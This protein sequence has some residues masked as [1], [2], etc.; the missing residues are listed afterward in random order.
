VK[1]M[2]DTNACIRL[3]KGDSPLFFKRI[4]Y[5]SIS[6]VVIPTI[7]RFE[8][9]YGVYKSIR[10]KEN[11]QNLSEFLNDFQVIP[12]DERAAL[13]AG[14]IRAELEKNGTPI[15]PYDLLIGTS[16]LI[17]SCILI[18]HNTKE[19]SRIEGLTIEDWEV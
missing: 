16:A 3:L 5:I 18:T 8:L 4:K 15:G 7:V 10:K 9:Y 13:S 19:F 14:K 11:L 1:Y 17:N 12:F 2:L 6:D